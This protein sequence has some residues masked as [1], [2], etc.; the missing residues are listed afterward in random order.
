[1]FGQDD[2]ALDLLGAQ[3]SGVKRTGAIYGSI[4]VFY[5]GRFE[6][7]Y[8]RRA[9]Y[10]IGTLPQYQALNI[11]FVNKIYLLP[12]WVIICCLLPAIWVLPQIERRVRLRLEAKA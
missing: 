8:L 12:V 11:W 5:N 4:S 7:L 10:Q 1:M 3:V 6:S 2:A 9:D